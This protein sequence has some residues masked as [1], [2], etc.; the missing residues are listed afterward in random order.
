MEA[1][2]R[3]RP[4]RGGRPRSSIA[5]TAAS[6]G[7]A[8]SLAFVATTG[9]VLWLTVVAS[10]V[11]VGVGVGVF[12]LPGSVRLVRGFANWYRRRSFEWAG[13]K[14]AVPYHER[15][16]PRRGL[17]G[18]RRRCRWIVCDPAT[19]RDLAWLLVNGVVGLIVCLLPLLLVAT[20]LVAL[21]API[22]APIF[23]SAF[24]ELDLA[25][26]LSSPWLTTVVGGALV[27]LG[28]WSSP[29]ILR[30]QARLSGLLLA[31]TG[32]HSL[33]T[34]VQ[35][36]TDRRAVALDAQAAELRRI[37]RD[38]HD[39][40]QAL[41]VAVG[42]ELVA[43]DRLVDE[44]P[45]GAHQT[46][47]DAREMCTEAL[48]Q[49]RDLVSGIHPPVLADRGLGDALRALALR[50][51]LQV[52]VCFVVPG[53]LQ[54]PVETAAYFAVSEVLTNAAKHARA[55]HASVDVCHT[56]GVLRMVV[57]DDGRGGA[58]PARGTG[59][60]GVAR[61]LGTFDGVLAVDSP[62]GGPTAVKMEVPCAS[63]SPKISFS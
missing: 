1:A 21:A 33:E 36:L 30:I 28:V 15:P 3:H 47:A 35:Q 52:D 60:R 58:D 23:S 56:D 9:A 20:G 4:A 2:A 55:E 17:A 19:W 7:R 5:W 48:A 24:P 27:L 26:A 12:L 39:G 40:A 43:A 61:R 10:L 54:A 14:I 44:D 59:L 62:N 31:P 46:L 37:E 8:V 45:A 49:L 22:A 11:L 16:A 53:R 6:M 13:V 32:R 34:R 25:V 42:L 50:S 41:L 57:A 38:L 51:P 18:W 29:R 63:F